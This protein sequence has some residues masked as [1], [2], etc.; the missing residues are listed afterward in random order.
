MLTRVVGAA[1][2]SDLDHVILV[3]G[4]DLLSGHIEESMYLPVTR[5]ENPFPERGMSSSI[6]AGIKA[7]GG[8]VAGV[9]IM[10]ADQ[11]WITPGIIN[12]LLEEFR[13]DSDKIVAP[14]V[15]GRRT[16]P[17]VFP[18]WALRDL[19]KTEGDVGGR[20]VLNRYPQRIV[21]L[22]MTAFYDD[23]DIDTPEDLQ[24][25]LDRNSDKQSGK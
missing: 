24:R 9:M 18:Y 21:T 22:D 12:L 23:T 3:T 14:A 6:R 5:V 13:R 4:P 17:V 1:V 10:L 25:L 20:N 8:D 7:V 15:R 11:P 16:T 2:E 19:E